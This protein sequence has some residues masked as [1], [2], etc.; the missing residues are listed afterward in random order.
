[1]AHPLDQLGHDRVG[2]QMRNRLLIHRSSLGA[3]PSMETPFIGGLSNKLKSWR[4]ARLLLHREGSRVT[5]PEQLKSRSESRAP[6]RA[7]NLLGVPDLV[8]SLDVDGDG[9]LLVAR[10]YSESGKACLERC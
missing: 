2:A 7:G 3:C 8:F 9:R 4:S 6:Q 1:M 10:A 5:M